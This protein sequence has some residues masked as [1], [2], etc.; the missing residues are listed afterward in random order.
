M[1][2]EFEAAVKLGKNGG[3]IPHSK[4]EGSSNTRPI[5]KLH[6]CPECFAETP[7]RIAESGGGGGLRVAD[8]RA[9][10]EG[11]TVGSG[12]AKWSAFKSAFCKIAKSLLAF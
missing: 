7:N 6:D 10:G 3:Q 4:P 12:K 5:G 8:I 11:G 1:A 9:S 2:V